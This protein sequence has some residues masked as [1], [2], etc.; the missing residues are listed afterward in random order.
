MSIT[1]RFLGSVCVGGL[2]VTLAGCGSAPADPAATSAVA[3]DTAHDSDAS[4]RA[5]ADRPTERVREGKL[6]QSTAAEARA[7]GLPPC[8]LRYDVPAGMSG[9]P[10][11]ASDTFLTLS[12]PPGGPGGIRIV[13]ATDVG[14]TADG[15]VAYAAAHRR[16][17]DTEPGKASQVTIAGA[18]R[19]VTMT[20][21]ASMRG[22]LATAWIVLPTK[23]AD[24]AVVVSAWAE[25][26]DP[27]TVS[28]VLAKYPEFFDTLAIE[29]EG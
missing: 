21:S 19:W 25:T 12:T 5:A 29:C 1:I 18:P 9:P 3:P 23:T 27:P 2:A 4:A 16:D 20:T 15:I 10:N 7:R 13:G 17:D 14:A 22:T 26:N 11:P 28:D 8:A 24:T 6:W